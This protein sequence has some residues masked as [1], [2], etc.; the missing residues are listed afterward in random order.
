M[1]RIYSTTNFQHNES[2]VALLHH[3]KRLPGDFA[4]N[5]ISINISININISIASIASNT[6]FMNA[7]QLHSYALFQ[8]PGGTAVQDK[9]RYGLSQSLPMKR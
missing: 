9:R 5:N 2:S 7:F 4:V 3:K 8:L 1:R 6:Q